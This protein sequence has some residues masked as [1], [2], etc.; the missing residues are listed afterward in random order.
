MV[1]FLPYFFFILDS[2]LL[3]SAHTCFNILLLPHYSNKEKLKDK[4]TKSIGNSEGFGL[5]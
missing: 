2:E 1:F 4:L 3:P 5:F